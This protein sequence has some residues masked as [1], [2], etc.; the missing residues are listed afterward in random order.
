M[1]VVI[2][3]VMFGVAAHNKRRRSADGADIPLGRPIFRHRTMK[4]YE[5][6]GKFTK[7]IRSGRCIAAGGGGRGG[8]RGETSVLR[9]QSRGL[10]L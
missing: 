7:P 4:L 9:L 2:I 1:I 8:E 10:L 5:I 3:I 6:S